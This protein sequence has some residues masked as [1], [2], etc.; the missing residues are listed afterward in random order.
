M[1]KL[2][3]TAPNQVPT[4]GDLGT[5]AFQDKESVTATELKVEGTAT[6]NGLTVDGDVGIGTTSP[7]QHLTVSGSGSQYT[8][9]LST[10]NGNT[11]VLFGDQDR[12]D[13][14]YVI[15]GNA[16]NYLSFGTGGSTGVS[17][18][19]RMRI[20][21][22]GTL[23]LA[24]TSPGIQ[25][26]GVGTP[27]APVTSKTLDDYEEGTFTPSFAGSTT[28]P[29]VT[30]SEQDGRYTKVGDLVYVSIRMTVS[31]ASGGAG[32]L[33]LDGLPFTTLSSAYNV[34]SMARVANFG[35]DIDNLAPMT[36]NS[37]TSCYFYGSN[38]T[39]ASWANLNA[40]DLTNN[41]AVTISG[42]YKVS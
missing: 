39:T 15:Y 9:I 12:V 2:I 37:A 40:T 19:E 8:N 22:S 28:N 5:M 25:F 20:D 13:S 32:L 30:Y 11:G 3:G 38:N 17:A 29:T 7:D 24:A 14:G 21:S 23:V 1:A 31:S 16:S 18:T 36:L 6:I 27:T 26:G 42:C 35:A 4:N 41:T 33:R 10:N 34:F